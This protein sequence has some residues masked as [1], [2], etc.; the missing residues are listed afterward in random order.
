MKAKVYAKANHIHKIKP[1]SRTQTIG[2]PQPAGFRPRRGKTIRQA[3]QSQQPSQTSRNRQ[4]ARQAGRNRKARKGKQGNYQNEESQG[5]LTNPF[6][7]ESEVCGGNGAGGDNEEG[8]E[9]G[10]CQTRNEQ[11]M[12]GSG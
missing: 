3:G 6:Q 1:D 12:A 11:F 7:A 9:N 10:D 8:N 4:T 2:N 5:G